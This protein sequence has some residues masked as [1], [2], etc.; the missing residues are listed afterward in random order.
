MSTQNPCNRSTQDSSHRS[1]GEMPLSRASANLERKT[2]PMCCH[3]SS[4]LSGIFAASS[5]APPKRGPMVN[6]PENLRTGAAKVSVSSGWR[7]GPWITGYHWKLCEGPPLHRAETKSLPARAVLT[8][9]VTVTSRDVSPM[10]TE[11]RL[12]GANTMVL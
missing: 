9:R 12:L 6:R 7:F 1:F 10:P 5:N 2:V 3:V 8:R 11:R 4:Q